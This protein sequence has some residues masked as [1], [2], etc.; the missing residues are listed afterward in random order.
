MT[1]DEGDSPQPPFF[2]SNHIYKM[3]N[4]ALDYGISEAE[5]WEMTFAELDR[6][7]DS[8]K[9]ME[10]YRAQE[11]ATYDYILAAMIG[12]AFAAGMDSKTKFPEIYEAY[13]SLFDK[14]ERENQKREQSNQLSALRFKQFAQ[15]YNKKY[16]EV[17]NDK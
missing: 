2:Y 8:K 17:A 14:E 6:L 15:S 9:R 1:E 4:N 7:V 3:L 16:K 5:F 11:R 13:P 10:K 12:R